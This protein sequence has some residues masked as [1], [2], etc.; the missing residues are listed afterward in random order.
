[1]SDLTVL[2]Y[3]GCL[4]DVLDVD[5]AA[6]ATS[7]PA[8]SNARFDVNEVLGKAPRKADARATR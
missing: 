3:L 8:A 7:K 1:V 6:A 5:L 2:R 4:A